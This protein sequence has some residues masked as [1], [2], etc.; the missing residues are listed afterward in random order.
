MDKLKIYH[1]VPLA[2]IND[3]QPSIL[4]CLAESIHELALMAKGDFS[5]PPWLNNKDVAQSTME[6]AI[7][8]IED[9]AR[10]NGIQL[11]HERMLN[12]MIVKEKGGE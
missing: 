7:R 6:Q 4:E 3:D 12:E 9:L 10:L 11:H 2:N 8:E 5:T 1:S